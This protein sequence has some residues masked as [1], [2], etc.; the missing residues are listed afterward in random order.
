MLAS[1]YEKLLDALGAVDRTTGII[2]R[3]QQNRA[4]AFTNQ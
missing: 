2:R 3:D 1:E 4:G